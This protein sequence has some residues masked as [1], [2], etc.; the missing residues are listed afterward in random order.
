[1]QAGAGARRLIVDRLRA[2]R[3]QRVDA[4]QVLAQALQPA[5]SRRGAVRRG[6][7]RGRALQVAA[8][9]RAQLRASPDCALG[10]RQQCGDFLL[11]AQGSA[12]QDAQQP[13]PSTPVAAMARTCPAPARGR[14]VRFLSGPARPAASSPI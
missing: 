4:R 1:V 10:S 7:A 14:A 9:G 2:L 5:R 11:P 12:P 8:E 6:R 13:A 3:A